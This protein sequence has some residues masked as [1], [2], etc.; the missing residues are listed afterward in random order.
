M[1]EELITRGDMRLVV[2]I[3]IE[4]RSDQTGAI[5]GAMSAENAAAVAVQMEPVLPQ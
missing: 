2:R 5:L 4:L 1:M 3:L